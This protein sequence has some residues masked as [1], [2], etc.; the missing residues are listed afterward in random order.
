LTAVGIVIQPTQELIMNVLNSGALRSAERMYRCALVG[1]ALAASP[2]MLHS[3][4]ARPVQCKLTVDGKSFTNGD[5]DFEALGKDGSFILRAKSGIFVYVTVNAPGVADASWNE[6][7]SSTHAQAPLGEVRQQGACWSN[8]RTILCAWQPGQAP[9]RPT[10]EV[11]PPVA[12]QATAPRIATPSLEAAEQK[13]GLLTL[14]GMRSGTACMIAESPK[15]G[16]HLVIGKGDECSGP[17]AHFVLGSDNIV[18]LAQAPDFCVASKD[19]AGEPA[20]VGECATASLLVYNA[21]E[22]SVG[23]VAGEALCLGLKGRPEESQIASGQPF[24]SKTC[25]KAL[26]QTLSW[27]V[28]KGAAQPAANATAPA[29]AQTQAAANGLSASSFKPVSN[30]DLSKLDFGGCSFTL[31]RGEDM[32]VLVDIEHP[33]KRA[34][35]KIDGKL[36]TIEASAASPG[37]YWTGNSGGAV[38]RLI[39]GKRDPKYKNDG[40]GQGGDGSLEW[41]GPGGAGALPL[42]W[43]EGC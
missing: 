10:A 16:A 1:L 24:V 41:S 6:Q 3:A 15:K 28:V 14:S 21:D 32:L 20:F 33:K 22:R 31:S 7:P 23:A 17:N 4:A 29:S 8:K 30:D 34:A 9:T 25:A 27:Q 35:F 42:R 39:K 19:R 36:T 2:I 40:G 5:C 43:E 38:L 12:T 18:Q 26:D 11:V 37:A 13:A